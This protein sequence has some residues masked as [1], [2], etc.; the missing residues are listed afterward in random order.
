M[1]EGIIIGI[2]TAA[3]AVICQIIISIS[4][5]S[6]ARQ[7]QQESQKLIEYKIEELDKKVVKHN[8]LVERQYNIEKITAVLSEEI[9]V[10]NHRI[11]DLESE[12]KQNEK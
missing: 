5:N 11:A 9:K 7:A 1:T 2:I 4:S 12:V 6:K 8:N 3:S 10:A